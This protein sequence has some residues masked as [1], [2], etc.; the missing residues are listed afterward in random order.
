MIRRSAWTLCAAAA[1]APLAAA[2]CDFCRP[3]VIERI[4]ADGMVLRAAV[5]LLPVVVCV[6]IAVAASY[7]GGRR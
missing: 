4:A 3:Q 7:R 2:A 5:L 6:A 1:S